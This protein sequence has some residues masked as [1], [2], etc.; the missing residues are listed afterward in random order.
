MPEQMREALESA[1]V[2]QPENRRDAM[3]RAFDNLS[4]EGDGGVVRSGESH[5]EARTSAKAEPVVKPAE[6]S[7]KPIT[8]EE[9]PLKPLAKSAKGA[10]AAPQGKVA[11]GK[12][13]AAEAKPVGEAKPSKAPVS[14]SPAER[15]HWE[16]LNPAA[17]AAVLRREAEITK[18]L[19]ESASARRFGG[20]FYNIIK[21]FEH[22]IRSSGVTP[23]Q[24]VDNLVKT[25]GILQT[26]TPMQRAT[27][28]ANICA[29]YGVDLQLLD[30]VLAGQAPK[31]GAN[32]N[33][34]GPDPRL[35]AAIDARMKPVQDFIKSVEGSRS[36]ADAA[37][38]QDVQTEA[39]AFMQSPEAEFF[40]DV[41]QDV[42]DLLDLAANRGRQMT[43]QEAYKLAVAQHPEISKVVAEREQAAQIAARARGFDRSR[44]ASVSQPAGNPAGIG[45]GRSS[46]S[47]QESR[48]QSISRAWDDLS[49]R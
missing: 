24:A 45:P 13:P 34:A 8:S 42:A 5:T 44:R 7:A 25:A 3:E 47:G 19:Q 1:G 16:G 22:L 2:E 37:L 29:A 41:R 28:V 49:A 32:G 15:E 43:L 27:T 26:G 30:Q 6:K 31:E 14:W 11:P 4:D 40:E 23:L 33:G 20:E 36:Q 21:P 48:A 9:E 35:L 10:P 17:K 39:E 38:R 46:A 18:G 12:Q